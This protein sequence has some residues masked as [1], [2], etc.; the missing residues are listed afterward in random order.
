MEYKKVCEEC[1]KK[2]KSATSRSRFCT[3]YCRVKNNR[4]KKADENFEF[5]DD[6]D[7][8]KPKKVVAKKSAPVKKK[9]DKKEAKRLKDQVKTKKFI[10]S[11]VG[12]DKYGGNITP[13]QAHKKRV[14]MDEVG[15]M[16]GKA[17]E[18]ATKPQHTSLNLLDNYAAWLNAARLGI[19]T[20]Q[21]IAKSRFNA[22]QKSMLLSK[23]K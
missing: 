19:I 7:K 10:S 21:D 11:T 6:L 2:Y 23:L 22:N 1:G 18:A 4:A 20:K 14:E 17:Q 16:A 5:P 3:D 8:I 12:L 13:A 9:A 15:L